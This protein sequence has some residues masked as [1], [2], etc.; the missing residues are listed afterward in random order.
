MVP[1]PAKR[2]MSLKE[3]TLKMSKSHSDNRSRILLTDSPEEIHSKLRLALTDSE[4]GISYDPIRRPGVANLI[5]I[6]SHFDYAGRSCEEIASE[7]KL[8]SIRSLKE[9]VAK[10]V[11]NHI[12]IIR[13]RFF[14]LV[15]S[16][17]DYLDS[18]AC[19]GAQHGCVNAGSTIKLVKV[20]TG[21]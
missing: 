20:A 11:S 18:V 3:P 4:P 6:L 17:S 1:A 15:E 19:L 5:E 12:N 2:V 10:T 21:L 14:D 7:N 13:E 9:H 8:T 16:K